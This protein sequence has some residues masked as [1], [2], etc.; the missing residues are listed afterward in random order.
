MTEFDVD[1]GSL[2]ESGA[3]NTAP[4]RLRDQGRAHIQPDWRISP[5]EEMSDNASGRTCETC[6]ECVYLGG[7][8]FACMERDYECVI[9][10]WEPLRPPCDRYAE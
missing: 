6:D 3:L 7:G 5:M 2:L 4:R 10:D 9:L 8:D 1:L